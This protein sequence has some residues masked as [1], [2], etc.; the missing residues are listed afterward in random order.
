ME[1]T[2]SPSKFSVGV[3][4]HAKRQQT[5]CYALRTDGRQRAQVRE[6]SKMVNEQ[7]ACSRGTDLVR[8]AR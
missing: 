4:A 6:L 8:M 5:W 2:N 3:P 1:L 7:V